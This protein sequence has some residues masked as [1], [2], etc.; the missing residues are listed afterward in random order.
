MTAP[1]LPL[2]GMGIVVT[3]PARQADN[4]C[5][6]IE[7]QGGRAIRFPT[8]AIQ[9]SGD[10]QAALA[11]LDYLE[12]YDL[13]IFTSAN[14]V[15]QG[16]ALR[17]ERRSLPVGLAIFAIGKATARA[18]ADQGVTAYRTPQRGQDSEAL[19]ALPTL[20]DVAGKR[21]AI[22]RGE[23]GRELL[24]ATLEERGAQVD[25]AAVYRRVKPALPPDELLQYW[26]QG[27]IHAVIATSNESLQNL[28]AMVG[29]TGRRWLHRTPLVVV[30]ERAR[31]LALQLGFHRPPL[32]AAEADDA[33]IVETLLHLPPNPIPTTIEDL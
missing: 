30:S 3:R 17:R 12:Q 6:L 10:P 28:C 13:V 11:V 5:R 25:Y 1:A 27:D 24:R 31:S 23:G 2:Q 4:L 14:A 18:L 29:A 21:I 32:V 9:A 15:E 16:L 33:A 20:R 19:L 26:R 7:A 22:V 8:L